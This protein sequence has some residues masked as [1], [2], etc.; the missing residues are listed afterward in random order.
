MLISVQPYNCSSL[1]QLRRRPGKPSNPWCDTNDALPER[2]SEKVS[3]RGARDHTR[4]PPPESIEV[5]KTHPSLIY[6]SRA[7]EILYSARSLTAAPIS[8][9]KGWSLAGTNR[10]GGCRPRSEEGKGRLTRKWLARRCPKIQTGTHVDSCKLGIESQVR[11]VTSPFAVSLGL[12][13]WPLQPRLPY[14]TLANLASSEGLKP[15]GEILYEAK[16]LAELE[17]RAGFD[18]ALLRIFRH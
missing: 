12:P 11:D 17:L 3:F 8:D 18:L 1:G 10:N 4:T 13:R 9:D 16:S 2:E 14:Q 6:C 5:T 15:I 7:G